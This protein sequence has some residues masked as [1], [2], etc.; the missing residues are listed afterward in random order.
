MKPRR[1][2][3][4]DLAGAVLGLTEQQM[5]E[6]PNYDY[7]LEQE[8]GLDLE[9]FEGVAMALLPFTAPTEA[10]FSK[11]LIQGFVADGAYIVSQEATK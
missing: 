6:G 3:Y 11:R 9:L 1:T 2:D 4:T 7:L 8:F 10:P 5:E